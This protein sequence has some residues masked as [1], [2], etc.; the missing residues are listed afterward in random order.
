LSDALTGVCCFG[1]TGSGKT[2]GPAK[3]LAYG[4]LAN[5]FGGLVLCAK[6]EE[7]RQWK[8]W[9]A[10]C[11]RSED[12]IIIDKSAKFRFNFMDWEASR[13]EEGGGLAINIV[14]LL[15]EIGHSVSG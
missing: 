15:D 1:A 9:A 7:C 12:L 11:G 4:Y 8:K 6:K 13:P 5:D 3:H 10:E 14:S 2:T